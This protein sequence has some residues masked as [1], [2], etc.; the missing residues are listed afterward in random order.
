MPLDA[1]FSYVSLALAP[2]VHLSLR[3]YPC[4]SFKYCSLNILKTKFN[5]APSL[6]LQSLLLLYYVQ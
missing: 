6:L 5:S 1:A 2:V 3:L 4:R